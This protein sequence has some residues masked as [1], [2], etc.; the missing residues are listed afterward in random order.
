MEVRYWEGGLFA[1]EVEAIESMAK[2]FQ[3]NEAPAQPVAGPAKGNSFDVLKGLKKPEPTASMYPWK[4]Y[5]GFR[6][7]NSRGSEGE[8]DLVIVLHS[9]VLVVELKHWKGKITSHAGK[10]LQNGKEQGPSPVEK[11]RRKA[12]EFKKKLEAIKTK[13]PGGKIP[14]VEF[15]VVLSADCTFELPDNEKPYVMRLDDFL[16]LADEQRFKQRYPRSQRGS[17]N[18]HFDVFDALLGKGS[19]K[20]KELVVDDYRAK[21]PAVFMHPTKVYSEFD[22]VNINNKDDHAML[23]L[24]DF[25]RLDS[26]TAR[27]TEG[28]FKILSREREILVYL[29]RLDQDLVNRCARFKGNVSR[30]AITEQY[31][32]LFEMPDNHFRLN[33]FINRFVVRQESSERLHLLKILL[34]Q[35][36]GLHGHSIAHRDIGDHSIWFSPGSG[37]A[38]SNFISAY[39]QPIGTVGDLRGLLSIGTIALPEDQPNTSLNSTPFKRDVFALG[40]LSWHLAQAKP[41][42]LKLDDTYINSVVGEISASSE[43][44]APAIRQALHHSP[45]D[46][47]ENANEFLQALSQATPDDSAGFAFDKR[48][49]DCFATDVRL[50]SAY[51]EDDEPI[52]DSAVK[53]LYRSGPWIVKSWP[54]LNARDPQD[55]QGP[56]L[57]SFFETL[58]RLKASSP[59][60]LPKL[61]HFGYDRSGN[62]FLVSEYVEGVHWSEL[63]DLEA[64]DALSVAK[65]LIEAA[66]ELHELQLSHGDLHP[67][68]I[69]VALGENYESTQLYLL[70]YPDFSPTGERPANTRYSPLVENCTPV[71]SDNFAVMRMVLELL[72]MDWNEPAESDVAELRNAV[73]VEAEAESG[74][75]SLDRFSDALNAAFQ[76]KQTLRTIDVTVK[77]DTSFEILPDN[78]KVYVVFKPNPKAPVGSLEIVFAGI[79]GQFSAFFDPRTKSVSKLLKPHLEQRVNHYFEKNA[80]Y[81]LYV[82]LDISA[83]AVSDASALGAFLSQDEAFTDLAARFL[84]TE[85]RKQAVLIESETPEESITGEDTDNGLPVDDPQLAG[86]TVKVFPVSQIWKTFTS[87]ELEAQ[88][89]FRV[90]A[91][92]RFHRDNVGLLIPYSME[93][94]ALEGFEADDSIR[95]ILREGDRDFD[96][97]AIDLSKSLRDAV[98]VP[99]SQKSLR[100]KADSVL[101][102]QSQQNKTSLIRRRSAMDRIIN[103]QS[104]IPDLLQYFDERCEL[105]P[106]VYDQAPT[107]ED[108]ALYE[109]TTSDGTVIGLNDAQKKAFT[110]IVTTGPINLLQG[111]PGTGKTEF[112]AAFVHYLLAKLGVRNILLVSQ[113]HEAVNTAA[114]RIR[115]HCRRLGTDLD[116][117]RFSNRSQVVSEE[118]LDA[119]SGNIIERQRNS[120]SAELKERVSNLASSLGLSQEFVNFM[121]DVNQRIARQVKTL[122]TLDKEI[123]SAEEGAEKKALKALKDAIAD[124]LKQAARGYLGE[125]PLDDV[126]PQDILERVYTSIQSA[127]GVRPPEFKQCQDLIKLSQEFMERLSSNRAN[128]DEFLMR[129]RTLVCGTCVGIGLQHLNLATTHFDWVI[130]DEAAR[131]SPSELAIAMQVGSRILKVGDHF[132]LSPTYEDEHKKA[133]AKALGISVNSTEFQRVMRSDFERV[134]ESPYGQAARA[135]LKTQYRMLPPIGDLV[136]EIFYNNR[137]SNGFRPSPAY[138]A[139]S[140]PACLSHIVTWLDTSGL[141]NKAF[142]SGGQSISNSAEADAIIKLLQEIEASTEFCTGMIDEMAR[143]QEP[144]IGVICMYRDQRKLI[145]KR[146]EE[147]S[148]SEDFRKLVKI[149]TC[150]SYQ[151]KENNVIIISLTRAKP[152]QH[153]GFLSIP[154]RI[155]VAMSRAKERLIIVGSL[156]MWSDRN[157]SLPLGKVASYIQTRLDK[158]NHYKITNIAGEKGIV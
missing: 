70:D 136:S 27:T 98:Y 124:E 81:H 51:R 89:F 55:G 139:K 113:S 38:L 43:W 72:G 6:F 57:M 44:Y 84:E 92:P 114:E 143:T 157:A 21:T 69:K 93:S 74:F 78:G 3:A 2:A 50:A 71:E 141:G 8:F 17:L 54:S 5:A 56:M 34:A 61:D 48:Q 68:N 105:A 130:I 116:V 20:P 122:G 62:P 149:E 131:S 95:L 9:M 125:C 132:Q 47:Y 104:V 103:R 39:H 4:G 10:W 66:E 24:W 1:F 45:A 65:R 35:F 83:G 77:G 145:R 154:N 94:K 49:L 101:Y 135:E 22:S 73:A 30:D 53:L 115:T 108:F 129:S 16:S 29:K 111:P 85:Q 59:H 138:Y 40:L 31:S 28:R 152:D 96:I 23:R 64:V 147:K 80:D 37:I 140:V 127:H 106:L 90:A 107:E 119:Y 46:R 79:G 100:V 67:Q 14:W 117:V 42:P 121:V 133:I 32:E 12:F 151:G 118:L 25:S 142:D 144:P 88:P 123:E 112:I 110:H 86:V 33:E 120:F 97:G 134:F 153:P 36:S 13:L 11:T 41:L 156:K 60:F 150:D 19:V 126:P 128:Y 155:N 26:P 18:K 109:R 102:L 75:M 15:C 82:K 76:P 52:T 158:T 58:E 87:T 148:W 63:K 91:E 7:A 99:A 137:L 146:F